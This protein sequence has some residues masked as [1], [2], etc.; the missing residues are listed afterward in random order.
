MIKAKM[1]LK[2]GRAGLVLGL[3]EGNIERLKKG[4]PI[5]FDIATMKLTPGTEIG[6]VTIFYGKTE[7]HMTAVLSEFIGP[8]TEVIAVPRG[9]ERPQ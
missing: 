4:E 6:G 8:D 2:D 7:G 5:F 3:S 1:T 9:D